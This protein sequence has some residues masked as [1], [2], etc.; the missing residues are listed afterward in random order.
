M[1]ATLDELANGEPLVIAEETYLSVAFELMARPGTQLADVDTVATHPHAEAQV[2]RW[3]I[4][5]LPHARSSSSGRQPV[6]RRPW[7]PGSTTPRSARRSPASCT[8]STSS[9]TTSPTTR[10]RSPGSCCSPDRPR[11]REPTGND[12]TTLVAY[13][14]ADHSGALLEILSEFGS[15][16]VNLTRIESR[17]TKQPDRAVLLLDRLR[18]PH[19][20]TSGSVTRSPRCTGCAPTSATS[21]RTRGATVRRTRC[22]PGVPTASSRTRRPGWRRSGRRAPRS[23]RAL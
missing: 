9:P 1:P 18:G 8:G 5:N 20:S 23:A 14:R 17:P 16:G 21:V 11:R 10:T 12:R 22:R 13:L 2:R 3:L 7:L 19:R 6:R 15:R 4:D